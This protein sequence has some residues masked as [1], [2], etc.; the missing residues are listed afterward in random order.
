MRDFANR[1]LAATPDELKQPALMY[2]ARGIEQARVAEALGVSRRT[3][4]YR[5]AE[6]T[7]RAMR[8]QEIAEA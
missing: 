5:L 2:H 4:L 3:V 1:V 8:M 7:R 6:F